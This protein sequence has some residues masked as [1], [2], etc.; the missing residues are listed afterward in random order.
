MA[1]RNV[2]INSTF[3]QQRVVINEIAVDVDNLLNAG[4][5]TTSYV[6]TVT[7]GLSSVSYVDNKVAISTSG[8]ASVSYVDNKVAISTSG[9][10]TPTSSGSSLTGIVTSI[11]AGS[12]ISIDQSTGNV[13]ITSLGGAGGENLDQTLGIGNT[14][15]KG[16]SVGVVTATSFVKSGGTSSQFLKADGSVDSNSYLTST[17]SGSS[18]TGI[19]TSITAGSGISIDQSTGNVTITATGGGG[20]GES[21]WVSTAAGIHTLSNVGVGTTNPTTTL[22]VQ[23]TVSVSSTTTSAEFVGGGSDLINLSG[24]HLVSYASASD[25]SNSAL[26]IAG[27]STYNQVGILTGS[28]AVDASDNFGRSVATSADGKTIVVGASADEIGATTG[29]GVAYVYD[30]VGSS[31][32]QVG[33]LTGSLAADSSDLFGYSVAT[34]ADGKTIVVGAGGDEIGANTS[35][36]I[37]Y[38]FDRVGSSFNQVGILT[39]SLAVDT[40]DSFGISVATSADGK[41]IIVGASADEIG[42]NTSSGIAYVYDRVGNSFNQV[43][44]LTG[45]LAVDASDQFG[46]SVATSADGKTIV[47]GAI[48]DEIGAPIST[49]VVYVFDR[50]GNSFNQVGI[51]TGSLAVDTS[52]QFGF[53]VATSADG[54]TIVVGATLDEIGATI[55]TGVVYVFDRVGNSFNQVG[56]LTGSLAVDTLDR[57]GYSIATSADG[58]TIVVGAIGDEI[59]ATTGTGVAYV[60]NRQGNSFNQVGILTGS[61]AVDASDQFGFSVAT[62]ADGKT[63]IVGAI[64]DEIGANTSSGIAYVFDQT[65]DTYVYSGPTGNIGIGTTNPTS[66]LTVQGNTSLE[67]LSVSGISTLTTT[68]IGGGTSTGTSSQPLQVTG[69]AYVSGNVGVGITNP[70]SRLDVYSPTSGSTAIRAI[71]GPSYSANLYPGVI[72]GLSTNAASAYSAQFVAAGIGF[73]SGE[74][75][76]YSFYPT[77]ANFPADTGP[78]RV[79][80]LVGGFSTGVWGTEYF[81]INVGKDGS[82]NDVATLTNERLRVSGNGNVGIATTNPSTKLH[83]IGD[84]TV[85]G[86]T[87][88]NQITETVVNAFNTAL[89]PSSGTLTIDTSLGTVVLGD[90]N[91]SVTTWAFT[92]V[93]TANSKATTITLIIDGDTAQT[94]GDACNVNGSA[95][96]GGVKWSGGSAPTATNNFDIITFTI[97][98]DSAGT[99]NVFGSGN[100]NFS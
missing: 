69:G 26:S 99:I 80:D 74:I 21:Y 41:T 94:Y 89:A 13:T 20:G 22:Q 100:T 35:S 38:V 73:T 37:A 2:G 19:V 28:L 65:R 85:S 47:V 50:V 57:F 78:R 60:F 63:I 43:G 91:A 12:G 98:K 10:L 15:S 29:T 23:G 83:V 64:S 34:S 84:S 30:R 56:I 52:D 61:L 7:S 31:F 49:G 76:V 8:L 62:S 70:A 51:L 68:L 17:S 48:L 90:L 44:I 79:V 11:T 95:V 59:G 77:F 72:S 97:V 82:S 24:T 45:S 36:G 16:M 58:K 54:K 6:G 93:P 87:N 14:S 75:G 88:L 67:T 42:A 39:G 5:A 1:P 71:A 53:S 32:N 3:D 66:K 40:S 18:L 25:I 27:I 9:L 92:N 33:I 55:S 4:Y 86:V 81:A 46:F 96:S